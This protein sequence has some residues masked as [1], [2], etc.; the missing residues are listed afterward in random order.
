MNII[1]K[2]SSLSDVINVPPS[3]SHTI[4][5][6]IIACLCEGESKIYNPLASADCLSTAN[7]IPQ[8]GAQIEFE[9]D[10]WTVKGAGKNFH[11]SDD[12]V[13]VGN[14]GSLLYFLSPV[15]ATLDAVTIF[16][17]DKSIRSRPVSHVADVINQLGAKSFVANPNGKTCPLVVQGK[18]KPNKTVKTEGSVSS[19]YITGLMLGATR[20]NG[21]M[22]IKL[23]NPKETP[24]LTMT[25]LWL[26]KFGVDCFISPDFKNIKVKGGTSLKAQDVTIPSDWEAVAFPLVAAILTNS[27]ITIENVDSS[28]SQGDDKIVQVLCDLGASILWDKEK[29]LLTVNKTEEKEFVLSAEKFPSSTYEIKISD[30]PDAICA[31]AVAACF[32]KGTVVFTDIDGCRKKETDRIKVMTSELKKLG[33]DIIDANDKL[34]VK[35]SVLH[36]GLVESYDDHRVAMSLAV[37]GLALNE[38]E[39]VEIKNAECCSV[40]FPNFYNVMKQIGADFKEV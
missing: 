10:Y 7:V 6:L 13:N 28:G 35:G 33:A 20:L 26:E 9:K 21:T 36:G 38:N 12:V 24:Y 18:A 37:L 19:Q 1:S 39:S 27:Q 3:K 34:I 30:F 29:N 40:S 15:A 14:S 4:R 5:A 22:K 2:K 32:T 8:F 25:K 16:T 17:G 23:S 11:A 31:L